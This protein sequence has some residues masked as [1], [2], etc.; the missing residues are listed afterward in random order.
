MCC[1]GVVSVLG[2]WVSGVGCGG[3]VGVCCGVGACYCLVVVVNVVCVFVGSLVLR[4]LVRADDVRRLLPLVPFSPVQ[5]TSNRAW[6]PFRVLPPQSPLLLTSRGGRM[7][8]VFVRAF[9]RVRGV[10][11]RRIS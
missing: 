5:V 8:V 3:F 7:S 1:G 11:G 2:C 6:H 9:V 10:T 4:Y